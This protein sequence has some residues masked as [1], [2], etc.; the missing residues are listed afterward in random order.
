M[1]SERGVTLVSLVTI[2][3]IIIILA[4]LAIYTGINSYKVVDLQKFKSQLQM[5]QDEIDDLYEKNKRDIAK[6]KEIEKYEHL[7][8]SK[9]Y[10]EGETQRAKILKEFWNQEIAGDLF[11]IDWDLSNVDNKIPEKYYMFSAAYIES[12]FGLSDIDI[13]EYFII[14]LEKRYVFSITPITI[15]EDVEED[16]NNDGILEIVTKSNYIYS[17][18]QLEDEQKVID[19]KQ[20]S[21]YEYSIVKE[22][23]KQNIKITHDINI[24]KIELV[25]DKT[26]EHGNITDT[27]EY[28]DI[29][30]RKDYCTKVSGLGTGTVNIEIIKDCKI[31]IIDVLGNEKE[32]EFRLYNIP[33]LENNMIPFI[34][35]NTLDAGGTEVDGG[36]MCYQNSPQWYDYNEIENTKFATVVIVSN[37]SINK[38]KEN[39]SDTTKSIF[40][41]KE[42]EVKVW[43]PKKIAQEI[44]GKYE[45]NIKYDVTESFKDVTGIW[46]NAIYEEGKYIPKE[47]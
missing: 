36:I 16:S 32:K 21:D 45:T 15:E 9:I 40:E 3:V 13:S 44:K 19:L 2:I 28:V 34:P 42:L 38:Y 18:Y 4:S 39:I 17:L 29:N 26:D 22:D 11:G 41:L 27:K 1:R 24:E 20:N 33:V 10:N 30:N 25:F 43:I 5:I 31:R 47:Y 35:T 7:K 37:D 46:V 14:N 23:Y 8:V 6:G 12:E